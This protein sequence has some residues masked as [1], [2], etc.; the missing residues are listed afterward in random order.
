MRV[1]YN[2]DAGKTRIMPM[3]K[4]YSFLIRLWREDDPAQ[5]SWRVSLEDPHSRQIKGFQSLEDLYNYLIQLEETATHSKED[6][7][8]QV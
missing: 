5:K 7:E 6:Q 8:I 3:S 1:A 4:Y 2:P